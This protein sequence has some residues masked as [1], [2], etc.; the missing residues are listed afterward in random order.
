M[1]ACMHQIFPGMHPIL[2]RPPETQAFAVSVVHEMSECGVG[3]TLELPEM[4]VAVA[5]APLQISVLTW[6]T[7]P[8]RARTSLTQSHNE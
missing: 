1:H 3:E 8:I 2:S 4:L 6:C 7:H 5:K